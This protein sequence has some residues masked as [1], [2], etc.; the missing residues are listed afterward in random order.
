MRTFLLTILMAC[1]L[2]VMQ[3]QNFRILY[4]SSDNIVIGNRQLHVGDV[5]K[6]DDVIRWDTGDDA[7]YMTIQNLTTYVQR[8]VDRESMEGHG[9]LA[10][11]ERHAAQPK[12]LLMTI[13]DSFR[14]FI[15]YYIKTDNHTSY[16]NWEDSEAEHCMVDLLSQTY[17]LDERLCI[18]CC[19]RLEDN[20]MLLMRWAV[21]GVKCCVPLPIVD[22]CICITREMLQESLRHSTDNML[23]AEIILAEDGQMQVLTETLEIQGL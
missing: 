5:F 8:M 9:S 15:D 22:G 23:Q 6:V 2:L 20:A 21:D 7:Q 14:S 16:R 11:Y 18:P 10:D 3:A 4:L 17:I 19:I 12:S 13:C 1:S